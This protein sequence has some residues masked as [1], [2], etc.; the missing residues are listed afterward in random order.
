MCRN[1]WENRLKNWW[2]DFDQWIVDYFNP[3]NNYVT[4]LLKAEEIKCKLSSSAIKYENKYPIKLLTEQNQEKEFYLSK[5]I[6]EKILIENNLLNHLNSLLKDLLNQARGKIFA[7][8][9]DFKFHCFGWWWNS[10]TI[11]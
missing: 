5:E 3:G 4:N 6:F 11:N 2:K 9:D 1:N 10:N 8:F 7:Q